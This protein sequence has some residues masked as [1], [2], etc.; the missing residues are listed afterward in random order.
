MFVAND[1]GYVESF[2]KVGVYDQHKFVPTG[3]ILTHCSD[4][5][6]CGIPCIYMYKEGGERC[7]A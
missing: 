6:D 5:E 1:A 7:Y 3:K 4:V 2:K